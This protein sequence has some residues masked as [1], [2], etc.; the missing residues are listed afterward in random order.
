VNLQTHIINTILKAHADQHNKT[1]NEDITNL[2]KTLIGRVVFSDTSYED[3]FQRSLVVLDLAATEMRKISNAFAY[4]E[5]FSTPELSKEKKETLKATAFIIALSD[6]F[7]ETRTDVSN[8]CNRFLDNE[9]MPPATDCVKA[10]TIQADLPIGA[11]VIEFDSFTTRFCV[12]DASGN[13]I[14]EG[15]NNYEYLKED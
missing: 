15:C 14:K 12:Y 10:Q 2:I 6:L 8:M 1:P 3:A 9:T 7:Q 11:C 4:A 13:E 5:G